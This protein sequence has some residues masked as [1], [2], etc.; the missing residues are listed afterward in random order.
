MKTQTSAAKIRDRANVAARKIVSR[1]HFARCIG[2][3]VAGI[4]NF[5]AVGS[6]GRVEPFKVFVKAKHGRAVYRLVAA[7]SFKHTTAVMQTVCGYVYR[8]FRPGHDLTV[9]PNK[10]DV[11]K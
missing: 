1:D 9:L 8:C 6:C 3:R 11:F 5:E 7:D 2:Q 10:F 4:R